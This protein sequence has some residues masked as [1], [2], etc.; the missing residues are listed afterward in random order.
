LS[1]VALAAVTYSSLAVLAGCPDPNPTGTYS[2][3]S[4]GG[5]DVTAGPGQGAA[6]GGG[7]A[8]SPGGARFSAKGG[9]AVKLSGTLVYE[10]TATGR[11]QLDFLTT[12]DGSP[13]QLVNSQ[14]VKSGTT[15]WST[16]VPKDFGEL[17]I[18]AFI[19]K[20]SDGPSADDPA[21]RTSEPLVVGAEDIA[22]IVITLTDAAEL[23]TLAPG[24]NGALPGSVAKPSGP[25]PDGPPPDGP[26][27]DG[28]PPDG[29]PPDGPP[30]DGSPA[31]GDAQGGEPAP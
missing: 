1:R 23:G 26:P 17:N 6:A 28:P 3:S 4:T 2:G 16:K 12:P 20:E 29:P 21:G 25:P 19:D 9:E 11:M 10:G 7:S 5:V 18:V 24:G 31:G 8:S 14:Q 15:K 30:P 13:P 22:D 27:P